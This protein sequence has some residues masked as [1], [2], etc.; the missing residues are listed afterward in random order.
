MTRT[1]FEVV[2]PPM[3]SSVVAPAPAPASG[4]TG[5]RSWRGSS[6]SAWSPARRGSAIASCAAFCRSWTS[7]CWGRR[8]RR[9]SSCWRASAIS[10]WP[11]SRS[12]PTT[13]GSA[14]RCW[15][16]S[17]TRR[18]CRTSSRTCGSR[19]AP[20]LLAVV[21]AAGKVTAVAGADRPARG[22]PGRVPRG[23]ERFRSPD[24][25]RLDAARSGPG[26]RRRADPLG[27]SDAGAAGEGV[28][29]GA[30]PACDRRHVAGRDGRALHRRAR[31]RAAARDGHELDE[32]LRAAGRTR[33]RDRVGVRRRPH[34]TWC[35][36]RA[37]ARARRRRG[38]HGWCPSTT[39]SSARERCCSSSGARSRSAR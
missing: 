12:S 19:R 13:T 38:S 37:P 32:P 29:A 5:A 8:A 2:P 9:W 27:R 11:R 24:V 34:A 39:S 16:R 4:S 3:S 18:P 10:W 23:Q 36:S 28:V 22:E 25:G 1:R 6:C 20:S 31:R 15:R 30:Q 7:S 26:R 17:S 35:A 14:R 33:R 21:D